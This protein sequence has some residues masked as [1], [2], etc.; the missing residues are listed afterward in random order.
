MEIEHQ[1]VINALNQ[2]ILQAG[3]IYK[4]KRLSQA[5]AIRLQEAANQVGLSMEVVDALL[6]Q[7]AN[8]NAV[9]EYCMTSDDAF[10]RRIKEDP[11]LSRIL[12]RDGPFAGKDG[13][14]LSSSVWRVFMHKIIQ[15]FLRNHKMQ[16]G[17]VMDKSSL[18]SRLYE[19][20]LKDD[21]VDSDDY[22]NDFGVANIPRDYTEERKRVYISKDEAKKA[23]QEAEN[24]MGVHHSRTP[25]DDL[26]HRN[27]IQFLPRGDF[28]ID[29][30]DDDLSMKPCAMERER[31]TSDPTHPSRRK[32]M[33][34]GTSQPINIKSRKSMG[35]GS[36]VSKRVAINRA[37]KL[38]IE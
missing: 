20:A 32:S 34:A 25:F 16:I 38:T 13:L 35:P 30:R 37:P 7:T 28:P 26:M 11:T 5:E 3:N 6:E 22:E 15:Q 8:P 33:P 23:R 1:A 19:D 36:A 12:K 10:A 31:D 29:S 2:F 17:D 18:T 4:G 9:V 24:N 21:P 14:N 27:S